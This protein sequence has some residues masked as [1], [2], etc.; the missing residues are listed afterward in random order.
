MLASKP[1]VAIGLV[2]YSAYLWHQPV[3]ALIRHRFAAEMALGEKLAIIVFILVLAA[4]TYRWVEQPFRD[5]SR[6]PIARLAS[7]LG[8]ATVLFLG[9]GFWGH[10]SNGLPSRFP[11][12]SRLP[13]GLVL[14]TSENG[15]CFYSVD[16]NRQLPVKSDPG[17]CFLGEA[18]APVVD[19]LLLGDSYAGQYEPFW[20]A[21]GKSGSWKVESVTTNWCF[22]SRGIEFTGYLA[23]PAYAQC[24]Y[25][26][27]FM[28]REMPRVGVVVLGG[29]W[30]SIRTAGH[31]DAALDFVQDASSKT[32]LVI[33]M[34][35]PVQYDS[36]PL[37]YFQRSILY[38]NRFRIEDI[39]RKRDAAAM[40]ADADL[41][42]F[43]ERFDNV[44]VLSREEV[45]GEGE[46]QFIAEG[47][48][49]YSAD[50]LH[51]SVHGARRAAA[52]FLGTRRGA[53][54]M[55]RIRG[56][57]VAPAQELSR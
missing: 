18:D 15:W 12:D 32:R 4:A 54:V 29:S 46:R 9:L 38:G 33:L 37:A 48:V 30:G 24:E 3:F 17:G 56:L 26:R 22:P 34:P 23:S 10:V 36:N 8:G 14:A 43:A 31:L 11:A 42:S 19:V 51:I 5:R 47:G 21:L 1:M 45:F 44:I 16:S 27:A 55:A 25:N 7:V 40:A 50:G 49:P 20:D 2:S 52:Q 13:D 39:S 53:E 35:T 28:Q 41:A 57:E 6:M